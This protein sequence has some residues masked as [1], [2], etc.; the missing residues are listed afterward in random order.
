[1]S[2]K[3]DWYT[4][5]DWDDAARELFDT[6]IR[7]S[8]QP[9]SKWQY[10]RGKANALFFSKDPDKLAAAIAM[11]HRALVEV[12]DIKPDWASSTYHRPGQ[13]AEAAG[14]A[15][16]AEQ[17]YRRA[18]TACAIGNRTPYLP[19]TFHPACGPWIVTADLVIM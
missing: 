2:A 9:W 13:F 14:D 8:R 5:A 18:T 3:D 4:S 19:G 11:L 7:R 15:S 6:R 10:F 16:P 1:M 17:Y 12:P